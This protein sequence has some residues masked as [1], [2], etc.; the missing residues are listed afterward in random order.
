MRIPNIISQVKIIVL[1]A[2]GT[3][4]Y[5]LPHLYRIGFASQYEIRVIVCDGDRVEARNLVRQN[6]ID[7]DIGENKALVLSRRYAGVFGIEAEYIPSFIEEADTLERLIQPT[8][9]FEQV[10]LLGCVDNNKSRRIC[11]EVFYRTD[12]LIYIDAGNGEYTGQVVCGVRSNGRTLWK[13]VA[14]V[15]PDVLE[16]DAEDRFPSELSCAEQAVSAPQTVTANLM[17]ATLLT[18]YLYKLLITGQTDTRYA[19]F[20][21]NLLSVRPIKT[22]RKTHKPVALPPAA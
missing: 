15:Y 16:E 21:S 2:G 11:H 6:F 14:A 3:G 4:G 10:I 18:T 20:S 1:G 5:V 19:T 12:N 8:N 17:A 7:Q 22:T 13:P 9:I